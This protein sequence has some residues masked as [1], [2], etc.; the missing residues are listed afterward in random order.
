[1]TE[2]SLP[3]TGTETYRNPLTIRNLSSLDD[4]E[5][6]VNGD[7]FVLKDNG[8]YWC[9]STGTD[10]VHLLHST[11]LVHFDHLGLCFREENAFSYWAPCVLRFNGKYCM[12]YSSNPVGDDDDHAHYLKLAVSDAPQGPFRYVK[13]FFDTFSI[14]AH[15]VK[16]IDGR[17]FLFYS[18]NNAASTSLT[19]AGTAI[20]MDELLDPC[21]L[22]GRPQ[23]AVMPTLDQEIFARDRFG[24][25]RDWHTIEG[26][27]YFERNGYAY[28][29][30]SANAFTSPDYFLGCSVGRAAGDMRKAGLRKWPGDYLFEPFI[31]QSDKVAG[32]GH[33]SVVKGPNNVDDYVVYHGY[34]IAPGA[35]EDF[36]ERSMRIDPV[37][38]GD[39][40]L[41]TPAPT[42]TPQDAPAQPL[43]RALYNGAG[44]GRERTVSGEWNIR[45]GSLCQDRKDGV[46]C[47]IYEGICEESYLLR[48]G[49]TWTRHHYGGKYGVYAALAGDSDR[50]EVY[51]DQAK[52]SVCLLPVRNGI[53]GSLI[54][55]RL[56]EDTD[57]ER[58]HTLSV[59]RSGPRFA[60]SVDD[61]KYIDC[62]IPF[63]RSTV[64]LFTAY[65]RAQYGSVT[66]TGYLPLNDTNHDAWPCLADADGG[67]PEK[68]WEALPRELRGRSGTFL[69]R[70]VSDAYRLSAT[71]EEMCPP[72]AR[73]S[74]LIA[75]EA[76]GLRV[77]CRAAGGRLMIDDGTRVTD[78]GACGNKPTLTVQRRNGRLIILE[79]AR[80]VYERA[81]GDAP[82][83]CGFITATPVRFLS[84][85]YL[86]L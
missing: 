23:N 67:F 31:A 79:G 70:E 65:T 66:L 50:V 55:K 8:E 78:A 81:A 82:S 36:S 42:C 21:T 64:G 85:E 62:F 30:Y 20:V 32:T 14:D 24:D 6:R 46:S 48:T 57:F 43:L 5:C 83:R 58:C 84:P 47:L 72:D 45:D 56:P 29:L 35:K 16:S 80:C 27:C 51:L 12:Y 19:G 44:D 4:A 10:G 59:L 15:A 25:G 86:R 61:V 1:M 37:L 73:D 40:R 54:E 9:Y 13:Q 34:D 76:P 53:S 74:G 11:D 3:L 49:V 38:Y 69:L 75:C 18:V 33:C 60:V 39:G 17:L 22:A 68:N 28:L 71:I 63:P 2:H 41:Y 26:A 7:P 77:T 52:K